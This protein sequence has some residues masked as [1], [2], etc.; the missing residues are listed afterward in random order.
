MQNNDAVNT[1][2]RRNCS[3]VHGERGS[4]RKKISVSHLSWSQRGEDGGGKEEGKKGDLGM[5]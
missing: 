2:K 3:A 5:T 4:K 1:E